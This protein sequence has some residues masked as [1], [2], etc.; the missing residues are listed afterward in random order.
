MPGVDPAV[1]IHRLYVDPYYK[2]GK[3]KKWTISEEK[4]EA[5][6]EEVGKLLGANGIRELLFPTWLANVVLVPKPNGTWGM[7]MDFTNINK[8]H[9]K[10]C[11]PLPNID[12]MVDS[13]AGYKVVDFL[14]AFRGYH[15]IFMVE[16]DVDKITFVT[17]CGIYCWKVMAF[18]LKNAGATYQRMVNKSPQLLAR[19]VAGDV[20]Q[21]NLAVSKAALSSVLIREEKKVQR[22]VYY[23]SRV[24]RGAETRYPLAEKVVFALIV[25]PR[26]L[27]PYLEAHLVEVITNQ[28]LWQ[29]LE[30]QSWA[31]RIVKWVIE[32]SEFD[33]RYKPRTS[34]KAQE[35]ADFMVEC[36]QGPTDEAPEL[37]SLVK[38]AEQRVWI[39][40]PVTYVLETLEGC[41]VQRLWNAYHLRRYYV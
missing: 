20:L 5:I 24:M 21:L 31:G 36:T 12:R 9:L 28:P 41:Q 4:G 32:L 34:I 39:L 13:S 15:K 1:S 10:D 33:L 17:E 29:I 16:E 22:P 26:K 11:Y 19:P 23:V 25:A 35:M 37:V 6:R 2:P 14:D 18:G 3:Q 38:A 7:C 8:A 40:G 27:K 30:N